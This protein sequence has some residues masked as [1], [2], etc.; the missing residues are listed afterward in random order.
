[1]PS[2]LTKSNK[3]VLG[4]SLALGTTYTE[5]FSVLSSLISYT[6]HGDSSGLTE[7]EVAKVD[8]F[9]ED[10]KDATTHAPAGFAFMHHTAGDEAGYGRCEI[11]GVC[12]PLH[13][14]FVV[15]RKVGA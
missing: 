13:E 4:S 11:L 8:Q 10:Q 12:G 15:Y 5:H 3:P 7:E 6:E 2:N 1:M 14:L 9:L